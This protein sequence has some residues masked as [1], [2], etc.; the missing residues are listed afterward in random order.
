[1]ANDSKTKDKKISWSG[2]KA[3][4][5]KCNPTQLLEL[6][7][8]LYSLST[9][10]KRFIEAKVVNDDS[11]LEKYR[12]IVSR[13]ISTEAPWL[14]SHQLSLKTAKKAISDY[15]KA[16]GNMAGV[17]DLMIYYVECGNQF[18]NA[19]GEIDENFYSSMESMFEN[20]L[21]LMETNN[22]PDKYVKRLE[23]IVQDARDIG[24]GYHD[25]LKHWFNKWQEQKS[26][27]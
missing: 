3:E 24:W 13:S 10:N 15:K 8:A 6:I 11:V 12:E 19:F 7:S 25:N 9:E 5:S 17:I 18:T 14:K 23:G 16:T 22:Y 1:M 26:F 27:L 4:L 2:L 21:K 20:A